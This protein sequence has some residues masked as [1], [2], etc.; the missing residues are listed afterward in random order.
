MSPILNYTTKIPVEKSVSELESLLFRHGARG[1]YKE[2]DD[3]GF[4]CALA[5][6]IK[7]PN[8]KLPFRLPIDVKATLRIL[9]KQSVNGE[10]PKRFATEEHARKIAWR[11]IKDWIQAQIWLIETEMVKMEQVFLPYMMVDKDRSLYEAMREKKFLLGE[12][13]E[14]G[15]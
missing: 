14:G 15:S 7:T 9:H 12:G 3:S 13:K 4:I 11:I 1:I 8:G 6:Y 10:I 5:F 2:S